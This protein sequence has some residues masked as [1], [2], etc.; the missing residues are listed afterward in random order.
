M[1]GQLEVYVD[2]AATLAGF[3]FAQGLGDILKH[4][5]DLDRYRQIIE[6][7]RPEVIVE[8]GT[9]TGVSA[10]WFLRQ[11]GVREVITIDVN[12]EEA[13]HVVADK[14]RVTF[15]R[16]DSAAPEMVEAV[17]NLVGQRRCMVSLD[18]DHTTAHV[19]AEIG[20]YGPLVSQNGYLVVEDGIF[21]FADPAKWRK[22]HFGDPA[23]GNP[24][25]AIEACLVD[26]PQ[27]RRDV[28]IEALHR[29][30]HHPAGWWVRTDVP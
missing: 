12:N 1:T 22:H 9:R 16:G 30:S 10:H 18:S 3:G 21:R 14:G 20:L 29:I 6:A 19:T 7:T 17:R 24:L 26:R 28:D 4:A 11:P 8:T 15:L 2:T 25:D 27:W 23:Q 13:S 5:A